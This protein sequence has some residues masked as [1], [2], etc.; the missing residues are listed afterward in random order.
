MFP[1]VFPIESTPA[2][3]STLAV[4]V[5]FDVP[6]NIAEPE[7]SPPNEIV[8]AV[9]SA[10]AVAAFPLV[11]ALIVSGRLIVTTSSSLVVTVT[12]FSVP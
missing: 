3:L 4:I 10:V 5:M 2:L 9:C 1:S 7:R 11:S 8:L 6:S 12:S